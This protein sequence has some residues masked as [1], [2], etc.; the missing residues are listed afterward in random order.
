MVSLNTSGRAVL[1][2]G[3]VVVIAMLGMILLGISFLYGPA[4]GAAL[5]VLFTMLAAL[6][7]KVSATLRQLLAPTPDSCVERISMSHEL[8]LRMACAALPPMGAYS[9]P[10]RA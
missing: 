7:P 2:A 5:S 6:T 3:I 9:M 1:F 8:D 10:D 4:I